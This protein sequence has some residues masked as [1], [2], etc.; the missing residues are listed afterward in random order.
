MMAMKLHQ[1]A[2]FVCVL[3][4]GCSMATAQKKHSH[5]VKEQLVFTAVDAAVT[6][7]ALIDDSLRAV[8]ASDEYVQRLLEEQKISPRQLPAS[9]FSATR[10]RLDNNHDDV[11]V[12]GR[13]PVAGEN[14]S[15]FWLFC[16]TSQ[17][18][19]LALNVSAQELVILDEKWKGRREIET[20]APSSTEV[21]TV[22]YRFD[23]RAYHP[24]RERSEPRK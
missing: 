15:P 17:G 6:E 9:W 21:F 7:P 12:I 11:L 24:F 2:A 20:R 22:S 18:Y 10:V 5:A 16:P 13:G 1:P 3:S 19:A 23:G 8:L 14:V 4:I